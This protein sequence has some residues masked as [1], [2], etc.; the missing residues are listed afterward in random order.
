MCCLKYPKCKLVFD[1]PAKQRYNGQK[2]GRKG[3]HTVKKFATMMMDMM[4]YMCSMCMRRRAYFPMC[5]Q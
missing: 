5:F 2:S 3:E 1:K 4:M